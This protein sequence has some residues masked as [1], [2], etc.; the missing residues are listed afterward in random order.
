MSMAMALMT[1][2]GAVMPHPNG[3]RYAGSKLC[4]IWSAGGF[5]VHLNTLAHDWQHCFGD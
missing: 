1:Y 4:S 3:Q 2:I 5:S